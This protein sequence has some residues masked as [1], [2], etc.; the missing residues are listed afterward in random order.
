[1]TLVTNNTAL[2]FGPVWSPDGRRIALSSNVLGD[3]Q[4]FSINA[5]G[6]GMTQISNAAQ[7]FNPWWSPDGRRIAF[8][9]NR[10]GNYDVFVMNAD[11]TGVPAKLTTYEATG[12]RRVHCLRPVTRRVTG[13]SS[14]SSFIHHQRSLHACGS[15]TFALDHRRAGDGSD[16]YAR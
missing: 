5:D 11:G 7:A 16:T 13:I 2:N 3:F 9:S 1:M 14:S 10:D 8:T 15:T 12:V 4:I 6:T